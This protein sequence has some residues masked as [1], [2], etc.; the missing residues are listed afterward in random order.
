MPPMAVTVRQFEISSR[1]FSPSSPVACVCRCLAERCEVG[2]CLES[3]GEQSAASGHRAYTFAV[4]LFL[5]KV[6][7][8]DQISSD[9]ARHT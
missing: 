3:R 5:M 8:P 7:N 6:S 1:V 4:V 2:V 9:F